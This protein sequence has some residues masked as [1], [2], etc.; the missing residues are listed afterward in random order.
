MP[1]FTDLHRELLKKCPYCRQALKNS[2]I[3]RPMAKGRRLIRKEKRV[4]HDTQGKSA[5]ELAQE[6]K[7][8][9]G[10]SE[11]DYRQR[12]LAVHGLICAKCGR[13]FDS[14]NR[15]LLT[16]HHI[17]G[18]PMNNP[19]DGSNCENLCVYCHDDEHSR[20]LLGS[21]LSKDSE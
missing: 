1:C 13:E 21:Y 7:K 14:A 16:V 18:N 8:Q 15:H 12:S 4:K 5:F 6:L 17:D 20:E 3:I 11:I 10:V 19:P 9:A 2:D